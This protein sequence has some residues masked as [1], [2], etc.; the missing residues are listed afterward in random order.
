MSRSS[1]LPPATANSLSDPMY[2]VAAL[3]ILRNPPFIERVHSCL[4]VLWYACEWR[5]ACHCWYRAARKELGLGD[6]WPD[7][8]DESLWL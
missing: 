5:Q 4:E 7:S 6:R 1:N 2:M 8:E 3:R